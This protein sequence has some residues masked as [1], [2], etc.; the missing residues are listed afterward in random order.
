MISFI[1]GAFLG[2][3][4]NVLEELS[5]KFGLTDEELLMNQEWYRYHGL[6]AAYRQSNLEV[7][8]SSHQFWG[9]ANNGLLTQT[10]A[11]QA[12]RIYRR[13]T[14]LST[15]KQLKPQLRAEAAYQP[16][17][18]DVAIAPEIIKSGLQRLTDSLELI[19][20]NIKYAMHQLW[21]FFYLAYS[22]YATGNVKLYVHYMGHLLR[23]PPN[24]P[25]A[26]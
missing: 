3:Y 26:A 1:L 18:W 12:R 20:G 16:C 13:V 11:G 19:E 8:Y 4:I 15:C 23:T 25:V 7:W 21:N 6:I 24:W 14:L 9:Y 10:D 22:N 5:T 17:G 2:T